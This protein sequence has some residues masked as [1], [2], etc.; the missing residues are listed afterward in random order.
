MKFLSALLLSTFVISTSQA[1]TTGVGVSVQ[2]DGGTIYIPIDLYDWLRIEPTFGFLRSEDNDFYTVSNSPG[3]S[4]ST[5]TEFDFG[6]GV[7]GR[8]TLRDQLQ[9]YYGA[10]LNYSYYK[11]EAPFFEF[12]Y[13][14]YTIAPTLGLEYF[15]AERFS[16]GAEVAW[17]FEY[18]DDRDS[19]DYATSTG[20]DTRLIARFFF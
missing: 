4:E 15:I 3:T 14:G 7:F 9:V 19:G 6:I 2:E 18:L 20:T 12:K 10:R 8:S 5:T 1:T 16:V 17:F 11:Y 13:Y